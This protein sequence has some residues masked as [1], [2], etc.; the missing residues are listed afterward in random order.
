MAP[1]EAEETERAYFAITP[2]SYFGGGDSHAA[3][4]R[5]ISS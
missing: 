4:R 1:I 5:S 3:T 2:F